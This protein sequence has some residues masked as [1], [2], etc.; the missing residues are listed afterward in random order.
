MAGHTKAPA[1]GKRARHGL[2]LTRIES[3]RIESRPGPIGRGH[4]AQESMRLAL[5]GL[6]AFAGQVRVLGCCPAAIL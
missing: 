6:E 2:N 1:A 4:V 5:A 3:T